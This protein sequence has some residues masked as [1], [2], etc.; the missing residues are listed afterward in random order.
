MVVDHD[1]SLKPFPDF[2]S[3][4]DFFNNIPLNDVPEVAYGSSSE[5]NFVVKQGPD[6]IREV[7]GLQ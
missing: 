2:S 7:I 1:H 3:L 4:R 5:Q 6:R